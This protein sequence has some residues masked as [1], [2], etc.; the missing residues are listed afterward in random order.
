MRQTLAGVVAKAE[1]KSRYATKDELSPYQQ[2]HDLADDAVGFHEIRPYLPVEPA[3]QVELEIYTHG[4]LGNEGEHH[5]GH[6][7]GVHVWRKLAAFVLMS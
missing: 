1:S 4:N 2:W 3:L 6:E 5:Y 7:S